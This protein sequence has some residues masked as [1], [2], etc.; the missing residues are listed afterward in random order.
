MR[1]YLT[2]SKSLSILTVFFTI[3]HSILNV[4]MAFVIASIIDVATTGT[5]SDF[6]TLMILTI[7]YL[8]TLFVVGYIKRFFRAK[9]IKSITYSLKNDIFSALL[10]RNI[11]NFNKD[12]S[13]TYISTLTNDITIIEQDYF[14][15]LLDILANVVCCILATIAIAKIN[16]YITFGIFAF[17]FLPMLIPIIFSKKVSTLKKYYSDNLGRFTVKLKDIFS[18]FQ[19]IKSFRLE[20]RI[21]EDYKKVNYNTESS[22]CKFSILNW[23]VNMLSYASAWGLQFFTLLLGTYFVLKGSLTLAYLIALVQLMNNVVNPIVEISSSVNRLKSVKLI[24]EKAGNILRENNEEKGYINKKSFDECIDLENVKFKYNDDRQILKN[25]SF[26]IEK[27]Y[28]YIIVGNSGSG[29]STILNLIL[30]YYDDFKGSITIDG[31]DNRKIKSTDLYS[32]ISVIQQNV[33]MF[34]DSIKANLTLF[35]NYSDS[36]IEEAV[37][38]SG[39][40]T[41]VDSLPDKINSFVGENGCNLSGGE[42][43]RIAIARAIIKKTPILIL[44][45]ATSSLDNENSYNIE[46]SILDLENITCLVVT[47]K[48]ISS[49][50]RKYDSII[51][52]KNG[53]VEEMGTFDELM[54]VKGYFYSLYNVG[55]GEEPE[56]KL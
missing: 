3:L 48:F 53:T 4:A 30:N 20:D 49:L 13:A 14:E 2:K 7:S 45:E 40:D 23:G 54:E 15:N 6:K 29:K 33:F 9:Y 39:L 47:H 32:L 24:S 5:L 56:T 46:S 38:L 26:T 19:V 11:R 27:G 34:D 37:R 1:S 22:K 18:G 41:L 12:N 10:K 8:I 44:D 25:V 43:Q 35:E 31:I 36:E 42:R 51:A 21:N 28:K 16:I 55:N 52:I 50:L 17:G